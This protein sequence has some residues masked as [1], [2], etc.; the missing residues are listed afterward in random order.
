MASGRAGGH[1]VPDI[2]H[3]EIM[4]G[5]LERVL[6]TGDVLGRDDAGRVVL[7]VAV[8]PWLFDELAA[9]G[10]DLDELEPDP[11]EDDDPAEDEEA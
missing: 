3:P 9:F 5:V 4:R 11:D 7:A 6:A 2:H 1:V 10:S 8:E